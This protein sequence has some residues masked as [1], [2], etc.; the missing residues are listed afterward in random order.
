MLGIPPK[1]CIL[2]L[3][4]LE[5]PRICGLRSETPRTFVLDIPGLRSSNYWRFLRC[6]ALWSSIGWKI[7]LWITKLKVLDIAEMLCTMKF[8]MLEIPR[9]SWDVVPLICA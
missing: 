5:I 3:K 4:M 2:E 8:D 6:C 1:M 9:D 7:G